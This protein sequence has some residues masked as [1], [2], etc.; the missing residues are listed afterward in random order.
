LFAALFCSSGCQTSYYT[1]VNGGLNGGN[2]TIEIGGAMQNASVYV[3]GD[4]VFRQKNVK[5][6]QLSGVEA[7]QRDIR[8]V[9]T[10]D[11]R[12]WPIDH[13]ELIEVEAGRNNIIKLGAPPFTA[14]YYLMN[15]A[16]IVGAVALSLWLSPGAN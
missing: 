16:I 9:A 8:I 14:G 5:R 7:G 4:L 1:S 2:V 6:I 15:G 3:D 12:S 11:S 10:H 13:S